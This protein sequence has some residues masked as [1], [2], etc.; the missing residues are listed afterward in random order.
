MRTYLLASTVAVLA[1]ASLAAA[2]TPIAFKQL[3]PCPGAATR[4]EAAPQG[5]LKS[6]EGQ[7]FYE[8]ETRATDTRDPV[9]D[10]AALVE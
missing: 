8:V 7:T 5:R 3:P 9:F 1:C 10:A 2:S 4:L 6:R